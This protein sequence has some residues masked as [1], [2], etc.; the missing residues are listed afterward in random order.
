[1]S[2]VLSSQKL[3]GGVG[4][5]NGWVVVNIG[6]VDGEVAALFSAAVDDPSPIMLSGVAEVLG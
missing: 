6:I 2:D 4:V 1:M 5:V 3:S